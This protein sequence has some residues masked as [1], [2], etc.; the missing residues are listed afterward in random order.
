M[1]NTFVGTKIQPYF[2]IDYRLTTSCM[3]NISLSVLSIKQLMVPFYYTQTD[4]NMK[5]DTQIKY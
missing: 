1:D 4:H 2:V 5:T 3:M